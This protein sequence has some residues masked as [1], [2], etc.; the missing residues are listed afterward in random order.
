M[1][2]LRKKLRMRLAS[3]VRAFVKDVRL[4]NN[5]VLFP[6]APKISPRC[7]SEQNNGHLGPH[8][9]AAIMAAAWIIIQVV[10]E[11]R[12]CREVKVEER[13]HFDTKHVQGL[14]S[15]RNFASR[16]FVAVMSTK[17]ITAPSITFSSVR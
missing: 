6:P 14:E 8:D 15:W 5:R 10:S 4:G 3:S 11:P 13:S 16:F 17:V 9:H 2:C 12:F 1:F 7:V